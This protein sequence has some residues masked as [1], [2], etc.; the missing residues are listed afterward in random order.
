MRKNKEILVKLVKSTVLSLLCFV[1][2]VPVV[3]GK[4]DSLYERLGG[5][6]A[7]TAVVDDFVSRVAGDSRINS[8]FSATAADPKRLAT[9]KVKLVEQ[10]CEASGG[11]CRYTGRDMKS[12]HVG[13]GIKES[14]FNAL[15]EDLV[16]AL[17]KYKVAAA[18]K[19]T[20]LGV[21]G[22]MK[23]DIITH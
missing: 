2:T 14:D 5:K 1:A 16:G 22:P 12:A 4:N 15:V 19:S 13:M 10:I 23:S 20:L 8:F 21:L 11:P 9:F 17:D 3:Y 6:V 18:D 7:I